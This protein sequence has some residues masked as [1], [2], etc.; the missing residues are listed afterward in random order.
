[1]PIFLIM[2]PLFLVSGKRVG[3]RAAYDE[4][5]KQCQKLVC[6]RG[7]WEC[8]SASRTCCV[9]EKQS[10]QS[11]HM[12]SECHFTSLCRGKSCVNK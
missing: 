2:P 10:V 3:G 8:D 12:G 1:M 5:K 11:I 7:E 9:K 4:A 6:G